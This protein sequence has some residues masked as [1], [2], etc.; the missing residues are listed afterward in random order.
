MKG[1]VGDAARHPRSA[2]LTRGWFQAGSNSSA[3][4]VSVRASPARSAS[5]VWGIAVPSVLTARPQTTAAMIQ[6]R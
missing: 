3:T 2:A 6:R 5:V 4:E 1:K